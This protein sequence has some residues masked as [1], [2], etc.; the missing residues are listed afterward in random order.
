MPT[1]YQTMIESLHDGLVRS[2]TTRPSALT[3]M[4]HRGML[5]ETAF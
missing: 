3:A 1:L 4:I 2:A 5:T